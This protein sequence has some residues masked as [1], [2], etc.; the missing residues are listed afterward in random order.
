M[1]D[2]A[3]VWH[4]FQVDDE[5]EKLDLDRAGLI[6]A[7]ELAAHERSFIT[8]ND[9]PGFGSYLV[10]GK[11]GRGLRDYYLPRGWLK[12]DSNNQCAIRH[13]KRKLRIVPCNFDELAGSPT[14]RPSNRSP[15]GEVSKHTSF[16]NRT[17]WLPGLEVPVVD[18][19]MN[20]GYQT[21]VLGTFIDNVNPVGAELS[22]PVGFNG[23]FFTQFGKRLI[24]LS[25]EDDTGVGRRKDDNSPTDI[26]D[27][28]IKRK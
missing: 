22:W 6:H 12:D 21:W 15:K 10:Y 14:G 27:I 5:L 4:A 13:P 3:V 2:Q 1:P 7:I 17:A 16:C 23:N 20:D 19:Q 9:A 28:Q 18:P 25:G 11:L 24:L 8:A 26:V